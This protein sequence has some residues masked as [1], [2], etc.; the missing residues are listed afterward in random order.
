MSETQDEPLEKRWRAPSQTAVLARDPAHLG[1]I[2]TGAFTQR[3][4]PDMSRRPWTDDFSNI[5]EA[6][7]DKSWPSTWRQ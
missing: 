2:A 4:A 7:A 1:Q 5:V 6:I 3:M